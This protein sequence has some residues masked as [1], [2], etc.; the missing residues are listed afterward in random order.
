MKKQNDFSKGSVGGA[1]VR[2]A[3]P[4]ILA[5]LVHVL[6]SI[7]DRIY[8]GHIPGAAAN[9]LTGVGVTFPILLMIN[10]FA[11][12][13]GS[14]G[15]PLFSMARGAAKNEKDGAQANRAADVMNNTF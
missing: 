13:F 15:M 4:M 10:A 14:G 2:M 6:Y 3:G 8:I 5:Q 9:A 1:I 7:V 12:L 11:N